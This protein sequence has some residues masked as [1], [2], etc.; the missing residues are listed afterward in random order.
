MFFFF[1]TNFLFMVFENL[2][3]EK[4]I[5]ANYLTNFYFYLLLP[6]YSTESMVLRSN[7]TNR[8]FDVFTQFEAP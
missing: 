1:I 4:I 5:K 6:M 7:Y 8:N 2:F 3:L